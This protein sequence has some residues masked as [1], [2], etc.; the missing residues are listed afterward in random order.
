MQRSLWKRMGTQRHRQPAPATCA[1]I[2]SDYLSVTQKGVFS[3]DEMPEEEGE[4]ALIVIVLYCSA[5]RSTFA[6]AV[7]KKGFDP[8]GYIVEMIR[9]D[10]I[11][12]GHPEVMIRSDNE[13]ALL[14]VVDQ[15]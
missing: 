15:R 6:L 9:D 12:L 10:V 11:W 13:P 5:A 4:G 1:P 3:P 2:S 7:P 8:Q 14:H